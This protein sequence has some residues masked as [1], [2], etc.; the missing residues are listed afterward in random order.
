MA[1]RTITAG[2]L[3]L[4]EAALVA[5]TE[6]SVTFARYEGNVTVLIHPGTATPVYVTIDGSAAT[7]GGANCRAVWP[8]YAL[9]MQSPLSGPLA[10]RL[11]SAGSA[12]YSIEAG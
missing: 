11:I 8:G 4:H 1:S 7:V 5:D 10:V 6:D 9:Q 12:T 2:D 3:A